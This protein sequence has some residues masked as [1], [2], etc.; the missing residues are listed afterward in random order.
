MNM[1][2]R[3]SQRAVERRIGNLAIMYFEKTQAF[4]KSHNLSGGTIIDLEDVFN[5]T[6]LDD[7]VKNADWASKLQIRRICLGAAQDMYQ[8]AK[9][10]GNREMQIWAENYIHEIRSKK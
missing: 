10:T 1:T 4:V 7:L 9:F 2:Y 5:H 6:D 8:H 3:K